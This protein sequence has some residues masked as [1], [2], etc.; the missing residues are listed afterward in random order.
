MKISLL[1]AG[2]DKPYVLGLLSGLVANNINVDFIG[3]DEM[4]TADIVSDEKVN[5]FNLRGDQRENVRITKKI[6]RVFKYYFKLIKYASKTDIK[7]FHIIWLNKFIYFD[8]TFL[9]IYYKYLGK[10]LV[11]TAHNINMRERDGNDNI[12]NRLT[13]RF[14][15]KILDH[16]FVHTEKMKLQLINDY[17]VGENKVTVI[18]FGINNTVP[19][20]ELTRTKARDKVRLDKNEKILLFFGN[21]APYKG[22]EHLITALAHLKEKH[23]DFMLIIAGRIKDCGAYWESIQH[24]IDKRSLEDY[25][26]KRIEFIPD[27]EIEIY[28][29]SADVLILPYK[30]IFQSG[31]LFLS[32]NFGLPV[33]ASDVGSF[34]EDIIEGKTGFICRT[35]DPQDLSEKIEMYFQSDLFK[36]LEANR[37]KIIKYA[38][39]KYPWEKIGEKTCAVYK[40][41]L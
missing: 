32:Y 23:D 17:N 33:I 7:L 5:Y 28:F 35:E 8:R 2:K 13:L 37:E 10:R 15:Y 34:R 6:S 1:T 26:I 18:P 11:Y 20:T 21:I 29:K 14:M 24:I 39:E 19:K 27:E 25:V 22:L 41:L 40:N 3:N 38:N 9:N 16:I 30:F 36:N 31:P 4:Q 12:I